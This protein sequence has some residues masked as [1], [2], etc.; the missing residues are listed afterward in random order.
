LHNGHGDIVELRDDTG[1]TRL[2]RYQYDIW[3][4]PVLKEESIENPFLYSGELWDSTSNLQYLRARWYDPR[5]GRFIS[6]DTYEGQISNP[7]SLNLYTYAHNNPLLYIDPTG[8]AVETVVDLLSL[9]WSIYDLW[10]NPTLTNF[11]FFLWDIAA[12]IIPLL[13]GS[14]T[15]KSAKILMKAEDFA[16][17]TDKGVWAENPLERGR[18]IEEKLGAMNDILGNN[19]K[20]IDKFERRPGSVYADSITS[21][22]SIDVTLKTYNQGNNF[23]N[24]LRSYVD[25]VAN[26]NTHTQLGTT[27]TADAATKRYLEVALPPVQLTQSQ[28]EQLQKAFDYAKSVGVEIIVKIVK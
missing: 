6:E 25:D 21:I 26:Y 4:K 1:Q 19:F 11:G 23:Y 28:A 20:T 14:Y 17:S 3:G 8:N 18:L 9:G 10:R 22:K 27:V 12:T 13:P 5:M 24:R 7:L 2:N 16:K 15:A